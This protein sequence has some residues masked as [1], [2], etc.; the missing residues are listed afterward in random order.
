[1]ISDELRHQLEVGDRTRDVDV[2]AALVDSILAENPEL[3][4]LDIEMA[5]RD[6]GCQ[7]YL[8]AHDDQGISI[9]LGMPAWRTVLA[10]ADVTP[11]ENRAALAALTRE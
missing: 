6:A 3:T 7:S 1:M 5:L 4:P 9:V 11:D 2:M 10:D 8:V